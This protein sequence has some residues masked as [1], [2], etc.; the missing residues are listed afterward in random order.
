MT[1]ELDIPS[2][3]HLAL[4]YLLTLRSLPSFEN[5][6]GIMGAVRLEQVIFKDET[7]KSVA[8]SRRDSLTD[9]V[10]S[11]NEKMGPKTT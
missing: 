5:K 1:L 2:L 7:M 9:M 10:C 3:F 11:L 8:N 6:D 4:T